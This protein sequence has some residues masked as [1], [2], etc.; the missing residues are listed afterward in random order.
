M[1]LYRRRHS[2]ADHV[3]Q[4]GRPAAGPLRRHRG[5]LERLLSDDAGSGLASQWNDIGCFEAL[6][7]ICDLPLGSTITGCA[8]AVVAG[9]QRAFCA[10]ALDRAGA[11][12][13][14][15]A[16]GGTLA[17]V[18]DAAEDAALFAQAQ[19]AFAPA[20]LYALG[21]D[22]EGQPGTWTWPQGDVFY[23]E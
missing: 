6:P 17:R 8:N 3:H 19:N 12:A 21:G 7:Y 16:A 22:D 9:A 23:V 14:C 2:A 13:S 5:L 1:A 20:S 18:D 4:L 11:A 15:A 10:A